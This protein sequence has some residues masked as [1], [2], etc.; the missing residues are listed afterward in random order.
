M[1]SEAGRRNCASL[2]A[3]RLSCAGKGNKSLMRRARRKIL[4]GLYPWNPQCEGADHRWRSPAVIRE[5]GERPPASANTAVRHGLLGSV[6]ISC[7]A[8]RD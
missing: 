1:L 4:L 8:L 5:G 2:P 3:I 6:S 7:R